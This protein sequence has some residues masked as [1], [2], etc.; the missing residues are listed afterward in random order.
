VQWCV[1][2]QRRDWRPTGGI[3]ALTYVWTPEPSNG[4]G[5]VS[6]TGL[7]PGDL[8]LVITD[9]AGCDSSFTYTITEPPILEFTVNTLTDASCAD[10]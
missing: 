8:T 3:G 1:R 7:C 2:W 10:G 9:A 5:G 6:A 4:Q